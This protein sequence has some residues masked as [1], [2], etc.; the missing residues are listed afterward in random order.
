MILAYLI[1]NYVLE[2]EKLPDYESYKNIYAVPENYES[3]NLLFTLVLGTFS[4]IFSYE[5]FRFTCFLLGL[6]LFVRLGVLRS[7][8]FSAV[9]RLIWRGY[10]FPF[11]K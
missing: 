10:A 6:I 5:M 7:K 1:M 2:H 9:S 8:K 4:T 3:W 11:M